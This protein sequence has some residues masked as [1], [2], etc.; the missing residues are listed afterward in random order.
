MRKTNAEYVAMLTAQDWGGLWEAAVPYVKF[1]VSSF[2]TDSREDATQEVL[3][4]VG[5]LLHKWD[6]VRGPFTQFVTARARYE[7]MDYVRRAAGRSK[8]G[9]QKFQPAA[10]IERLVDDDEESVLEPTYGDTWGVPEG[11]GSPEAELARLGSAAAVEALLAR[12]EPSLALKFRERWGLPIL[13]EEP[14]EAALADIADARGQNRETVRLQIEAGKKYLC[15]V[16]RRGHTSERGSIY[17]PPGMEPWPQ[18]PRGEPGFF[19]GRS[20]IVNDVNLWRDNV[21]GVWTDWAWKPS[22][23]DVLRGCKR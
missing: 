2:K 7:M 9:Q 13:D 11:F 17:P 22:D 3:L 6:P 10:D 18:R 16:H 20:D 15:A 14:E 4:H 8:K 12:L 1:A 23:A 19:V 21:S 5:R